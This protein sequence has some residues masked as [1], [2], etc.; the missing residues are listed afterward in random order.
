M[1]PAANVAATIDSDQGPCAIAEIDGKVW[2]TNNGFRTMTSIDTTTNEVVDQIDLGQGPCGIAPSDDAL[3]IGLLGE[4]DLVRFDPETLEITDRYNLNGQVWD[5]QYGHGSIWVSVRATNE[6]L[7]IDPSTKE[8]TNR[9][10]T[11]SQPGGV[12]VTPTEIWVACMLGVVNRFD[13]ETNEALPDLEFDG[14]PSWFARTD[15]ARR[16]VLTLTNEGQ[17]IVIDTATTD[18]ISTL[19]VPQR[20]RDPGT[21]D[22]KFWVSSEADN[23]VTVIDPETGQID[24]AFSLPTAGSIWTAEGL[25]SDGWI[26]DFGR[27]Q[28]FRINDY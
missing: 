8:I 11:G 22:G 23:I 4:G 12:V 26:L 6:L 1:P 2:V 15:D 7:R 28:I 21:V 5:V 14:D 9:W 27:R 17:A 20:P 25:A 19:T 10:P 13:A 18:V 16:V 3:W 24:D